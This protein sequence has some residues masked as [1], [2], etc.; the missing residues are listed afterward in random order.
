MWRKCTWINIGVESSEVID[1]MF[2]LIG[3]LSFIGF[4]G[5]LSYCG[6]S[7]LAIFRETIS[8]NSPF[9]GLIGLILGVIG[10]LEMHLCSLEVYYVSKHINNFDG[11]S[12]SSAVL[13]TLQI[14]G[15]GKENCMEYIG[16]TCGKNIV[17]T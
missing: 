15:D 3:C 17:T 4:K 16:K 11:I 2:L 8:L 5:S 7:Q 9:W 10:L 13:H 6:S 14:S 12:A 1:L